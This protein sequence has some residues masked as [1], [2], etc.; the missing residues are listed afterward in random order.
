MPNK[1]TYH[2]FQGPVMFAKV[3]EHNRDQGEFAP[4]GGQYTIDIGLGEKDVALVKSWNNRYSAKKYRPP[5]DERADPNFEYYQFKRKHELYN[6]KGELI[7]TWSGPPKVID[8]DGNP[9]TGLIWN[10]SI[11]TVKLAVTK[12]SIQRGKSRIPVTFVRLEGVRVDKLAEPPEDFTEQEEQE[13][14]QEDRE[15]PF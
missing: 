12:S 8:K 2:Y 3:F 9:F 4:E 1:T 5:H 11:C 14:K 7:E 10:G 6:R 13:Q 15:L